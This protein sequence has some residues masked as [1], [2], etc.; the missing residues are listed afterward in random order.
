MR[1]LGKKTGLGMALFLLIAAAVWG[2]QEPSTTP[3]PKTTE[4]AS[5]S[6]SDLSKAYY[7][8]I[9]ARRYR[10]LAGISNRPDLVERAI[11]EYKQALEA[12]PESLFLRTELAELYWRARR[13]ADAIHEAETVLKINP[14]YQD[15]H[16]LLAQIYARGLS[17]SEPEKVV[18]ENLSK[19]I[20]HLEAV[21]RLNPSDAEN[22]VS[23][24]RLYKQ[25]NEGAKAEKAFKEALNKEPSA[26]SALANLAQL[27][28][29]QGEY[30]QAIDSLQKI[31]EDELDP[32]LLGML[33][34]AYSQTRDL[35]RAVAM[36][37]KAL[38]QDPENH[39]IR[40][41]YSEVLMSNGKMEAARNELEKILKADPEDGVTY[42]RLAQLDVKQGRF[43]QARQELDRAKSLLPDSMEVPYQQALLED[44]VGNQDRAIPI[45]QE[46]IRRTERPDG[47]Y[48]V[49]EGNNRAVFLE[50][51]GLIYRS[52]EKFDQALEV[53]KQVVAL[54]RN[55]APRA[56]GLIIE[57]LRLSHRP[58]EAMRE[59]DAATQKYPEDRALRVLRATLLGENGR[60]DEA[61]GQLQSLL[62]NIPAD[63]EIYLSIA[64]VY[65]QAKRFPEA[66]AA[67]QKALALGP[68][69]EDQEYALFV[70]GS[71]YERQKKYDLAEQQFKKVLSVNPLNAAAANYLGYMLA[72]RGVRLEESVRYIKK[73]VD[74]E[75]NNGA[76]WDSLGWVYFKMHRLD[77]AVPPLEKAARLVS[78]DPTIHEHLGRLYLQMGKQ[79]QA[80]AE[81]ERALKNWPNSVTSDFDVDQ[82]AKL[83]KDL[84]ELKL[85]LAKEKSAQH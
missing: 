36:F 12:D 13:Q 15:A 2:G 82:A 70:L 35:N 29:E 25:N 53:F 71:I 56:E 39:E 38:A 50:R 7:H 73:A 17:E 33:A 19:A 11:S 9:L 24:G 44:L 4:Q 42:L 20:A 16:R 48:T 61:T 64:Q 54:G 76:Y 45:L 78:N 49:S 68:K 27:Y 21:A 59:A 79:Q 40:R 34:F 62:K 51:L 66:E 81:W 74:L 69:P 58:Q 60:L 23:L 5:D 41:A 31:P 3:S 77:L 10:E 47:H 37:E 55:Q 6:T 83:R 84:D 26:K 85:R 43:E 1:P 80:Q 32:Q 72:D 75:P 30:E 14:D 67:I 8:F 65:S 57:T 46:L 28:F 22:F 52:Q 63:R 18:K